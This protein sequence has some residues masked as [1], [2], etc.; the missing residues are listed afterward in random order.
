VF[1][2]PLTPNPHSIPTPPDPS[3][4]QRFIYSAFLTIVCLACPAVVIWLDPWRWQWPNLAFLISGNTSA[5][6]FFWLVGPLFWPYF[7]FQT[8][9]GYFRV[10]AMVSGLV[11]SQKSKAWKVTKKFGK[12]KK[13]G[14]VHHKPYTL[15][16]LMALYYTVSNILREYRVEAA[17]GPTRFTGQTLLCMTVD[18]QADRVNPD[19]VKHPPLTCPPTHTHTH[20]TAGHDFCGMLVSAVAS[21]QLYLDHD[22]HL[23]L[24]LLWGSHFLMRDCA[25]SLQLAVGGLSLQDTLGSTTGIVTQEWQ[26]VFWLKHLLYCRCC[27]WVIAISCTQDRWSSTGQSPRCE[28]RAKRLP[29]ADMSHPADDAATASIF[30]GLEAPWRADCSIHRSNLLCGS[31]V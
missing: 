5:L 13:L 30:Y 31:F 24:L 3:T 20:R 10:F 1:A 15:E 21:R 29:S 27:G 19:P 28:P 18:R 23:P 22:V 7:L 9:V 12:G 8:G 16:L 4:T 25:I 14:R 11:G 17:G 6:V 26:H 2:P